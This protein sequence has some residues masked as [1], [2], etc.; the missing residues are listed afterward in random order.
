[1]GVRK[2]QR[3]LTATER[4]N[5]VNAVLQL[6]SNGGYDT[7]VRQHIDRASTDGQ[8]G[9]QRVGHDTP[10]F[11][12]WHRKYLVEFENALKAID[13]SVNLPYWDWTTDGASSTLWSNDFMG[14][15]GVAAQNYRVASGPFA[16]GS[17]NWTL[18]V[19][20]DSFT[21]LRRRLANGVTL[22]TAADI[23][24]VLAIGTY[25]TSPW[26]RNATGSFRNA[27]E[28]FQ[29]PNLHNRVHNW[30]G[31]TMAGFGSPNDP[32]FWLHHCN[33]DRLWAQW[34]ARFPAQSYLPGTPTNTVV[35]ID[36]G[37]APW[38]STVTPRSQLDHTQWYTYQ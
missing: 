18:N 31:G 28:G 2:N 12:P 33:V 5:F 21:F 3:D 7:F 4:T 32:V 14:P 1:M 11:L 35:S 29:G 25:D 38:A 34:Q 15:S 16:Q 37:M 20:S 22:P 36:G 26:N 27:L 30:V 24:T 10:S 23:T 8:F 6:K 19:R 17:G 9:A 13:P